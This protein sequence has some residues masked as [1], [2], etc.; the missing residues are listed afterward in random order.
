LHLQKGATKAVSGTAGGNSS[1]SS[2]SN[3]S[4]SSSGSSKGTKRFAIA[5]ETG[6]RILFELYLDELQ[7]TEESDRCLRQEPAAKS[8]DNSKPLPF[9][10]GTASATPFSLREPLHIRHASLWKPSR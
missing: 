2:S 6:L 3:S 4:S 9:V 10:A 1:S 7:T 8:V 5:R